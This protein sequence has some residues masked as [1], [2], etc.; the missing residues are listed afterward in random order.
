MSVLVGMSLK[1]NIIANYVSQI[2][3]TV[4]GIVI[5]PVYLQFM[6]AEAYGLIGFFTMLQAW[7]NLLDMGLKPTI[8]RETARFIGGATD[9]ISFLRLVRAL[10]L[11]FFF[12]SA[13]GGFSLFLLSET[14]VNGWLKV[15]MLSLEDVQFSVKVMAACVA[16][17]AMSGLYR[18]VVNGAELLVWLSGYNIIIA[19]L[20]FVGVLPVLI[21]VGSGPVVFFTYQLILA[22]IELCVVALKAQ[23][24][25]PA[26][27]LNQ[28]IGWNLSPVKPVLKFSL[29]IAFTSSVWV[30]VTQTDKLVLS[31]LLT[32]SE[33]GYF[34]LAVLVAGGVMMVSGPVGNAIMPRMA[35]LEAADNHAALIS[36]YRSASQW[37][38]V[39]IFPVAFTLA[40]FSE[41]VVWAWTGDR[42]AA[43][44]VAPILSLYAVGYGFLAIAAFPYYLQ[45]AKGDLKLHLIGN[46]FFVI[47]LIPSIVV[48][49]LRFGGVGAG[50]AWLV[51]NVIYFFIWI[52]LVHHRF[53]PGLHLRWM[54]TDILPLMLVS[55][56]SAIFLSDWVVFSGSRI[57]DMLTAL[58]FG[59]GV[60]LITSLASKNMWIM[61]HNTIT[62]FRLDKQNV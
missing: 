21:I 15:E 28:K 30:L 27:S 7:F 51:S 25:M 9:A 10:Q 23:S 5:F 61:V 52:P 20:R 42:I 41:P 11:I 47:I 44:A 35:R 39:V 46:V 38:A 3:V 37:L 58:G 26:L 36:F 33:Y 43:G 29:T 60:L 31:K 59:L 19:S 8:A 62:R 14:I 57:I 18:G 4:I 50:W 32:L 2:Y 54:I 55:G 53:E 16:M 45:Y 24:L 34:T 22:I 12:L 13:L 17:R 40:A 56:C 1:K 48:A 49:T 6:G